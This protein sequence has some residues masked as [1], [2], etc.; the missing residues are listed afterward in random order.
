MLKLSWHAW[1]WN[2]KQSRQSSNAHQLNVQNTVEALLWVDTLVLKQT[3]LVMAALTKPCLNSSSYTLCKQPAPVAYTF[4]ASHGCPLTGA[5]IVLN[6]MENSER[7]L[8]IFADL[9]SFLGGYHPVRV[10]D[11]FNNRYSIIRKLGWGHFSTVWLA[12][13]VK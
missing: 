3:A 13:D 10:G 4:S 2:T 9:F 7:V 11:L 6:T 8:M 5:L 1:R 12:W